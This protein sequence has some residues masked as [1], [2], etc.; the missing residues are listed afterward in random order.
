MLKLEMEKLLNPEL[1]RYDQK[2]FK[3]RQ[4]HENEEDQDVSLSK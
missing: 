4:V 1:I 3:L 2:H